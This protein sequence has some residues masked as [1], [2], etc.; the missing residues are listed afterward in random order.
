MTAYPGVIAN[1]PTA[2]QTGRPPYGPLHHRPRDR[3]YL[4]KWVSLETQA[5]IGADEDAMNN[6]SP[7]SDAANRD[8]GDDGLRLTVIM[9]S[10]QTATL[11]YTVTVAAS[12][13]QEAYVNV[14]CD[15]NR[16]GDWND[17]VTCEVN[18]VPE[19]AV[20]NHR[21]VLSGIG[22]HSCTTPAFRCWHPA[23]NDIDPIWLRITIA[24]QPW[25]PPV[26]DGI[27]GA[28]PQGGYQY[29]ETEDYYVRPL[30][31]SAACTPRDWG[32]VWIPPLM[33]G[34][35]AAATVEIG[36]GGAV[37][38]GW[39][40]FNNDGVWQTEEQVCDGFLPDGVHVIRFAVP[41]GAAAGQTLARFM[42]SMQGGQ[43]PD[44]A[45]CDCEVEVEDRQVHIDELPG[46][47]TAWCQRPDPTPHG[48]DIRT[49]DGISLSCKLADDFE[50]TTPGRLTHIRLWGSWEDDCRGQIK[51]I[52]VA[53]HP[54]DPAG[55]DG[56]DRLNPYAKP[57][58][59]TLWQ[60]DISPG[61]IEETPYYE[62]PIGGR[63]W[64]RPYDDAAPSPHTQIWQ[65]DVNVAPDGAFVQDGS[66]STYW[67]AVE[68]E[69]GDGQFGWRTRQWPEHSGGDAV[70]RSGPDAQW[71]WQELYYP[72]GHPYYDLELNS[73]DMAFCLLFSPQDHPEQPTSQPPSITCCPAIETLCPSVE[74]Q[75]P[76]VATRC[77][78]TVTQCP[79]MITECPI[80]ETVCPTGETCCPASATECPI[81]A[82]QCPISLTQCHGMQTFC[83]PVETMCP[84][85]QTCCPAILTHC[86]PSST[87]CPV[88]FT[89]CTMCTPLTL[90]LDSAGGAA[91]LLVAPSCPVVA[92]DCP[93]V[94]R[95]EAQT[96]APE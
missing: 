60:A 91:T 86:P 61:Q 46:A 92:A 32:D 51:K 35:P 7:Q 28:G 71:A 53:I 23:P 62:M 16:D 50:C 13:A 17:T 37:V 68:I 38:Q 84:V 45:A 70:R 78:P 10:C 24:E 85:N 80:I 39:I 4:G 22:S 26:D 3:F 19:W 74:T 36:E 75:C 5:D 82:T 47:L 95:Y 65:I 93:T 88:G 25:K 90:S 73:I 77:P 27:G 14:W 54:D 12:S 42:M 11:D 81:V 83:P 69:T 33:Q 49:D 57:G 79:P 1:F 96:G 44:T 40:D 6:L 20:Q 43:S 67:L 18:D 2:Y 94:G 21:I 30:S 89:T 59:E 63:W 48:I 9:P 31:K 66:S 76:V 64:D 52:H 29:G 8:G 58:P 15:W 34:F 87:Q 55:P 41:T 56:T 72:Q